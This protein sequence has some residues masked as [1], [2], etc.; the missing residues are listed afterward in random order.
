MHAHVCAYMC[1]CVSVYIRVYTYTYPKL[2]V[3]SGSFSC[4]LCHYQKPEASGS[5]HVK[6]V[7][8]QSK[9]Q[10]GDLTGR[11][12]FACLGT[13][14]MEAGNSGSG[15]CIEEAGIVTGMVF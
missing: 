15:H 12:C 5:S 3:S 6:E 9:S 11:A 2:A 8:S 13:N 7:L 4:C 10:L 14:C 1:I